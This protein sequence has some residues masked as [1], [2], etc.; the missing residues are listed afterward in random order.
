MLCP[1]GNGGVVSIEI[2]IEIETDIE[3]EQVKSFEF[4]NQS[5]FRS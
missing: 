1:S 4:L 3:G 2:E 5:Y